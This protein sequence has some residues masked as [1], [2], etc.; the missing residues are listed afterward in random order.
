MTASTEF[1][2]WNV[3]CKNLEKYHKPSFRLGQLNNFQMKKVFATTS[4][5]ALNNVS[6]PKRYEPRCMSTSLILYYV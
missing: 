1:E 2:Y 5:R 3:P 6:N 4:F